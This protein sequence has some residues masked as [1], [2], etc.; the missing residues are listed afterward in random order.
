[1]SLWSRM[2]NVFRPERLNREID[3]EQQSHIEE[4]IAS[5][6]DPA[7]ARRA[8]GST[9]RAR[10]AS[11]AARTSG[12]LEALG[13]DVRFGVRLLIKNPGFTLVAVLTLALGIGGNTAIFSIVNGVLLN[14][15]PFPHP[16]QLVSVHE[17]KP[18]FDKGAISYPN[19][20]DWRSSNHTFA[21]IAVG[22]GW[23][24]SMTGRGDAVQL[25]ANF[26]SSGY[27][28]VLGVR[29]L[30]G[31]EFNRDEDQPGRPPV[32]MISEDL[33]R[34]KF[35]GSPDALGQSI[36]LASMA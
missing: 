28:A 8:F 6:R 36:T 29:P 31:R 10:E 7:E 12:R 5:G 20:L 25:S 33:W 2:A 9:L 4:A 35:N 32:A 30:L 18:N 16:E 1:M 11:H 17:S 13:Q 19:F 14:P 15:L 34:R 26:I 27:F 23:S 21:G 22:R 24:F 3:E